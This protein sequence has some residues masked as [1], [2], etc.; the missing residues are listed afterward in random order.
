MRQVAIAF[1][2]TGPSPKAGHRICEIVLVGQENGNRD[3]SPVRFDFSAMNPTNEP[4]TF[5]VVLPALKAFV[6]DSTLIVHD[7][8]KWRRFLRAELRTIKRHGAGRLLN[9]VIDIGAW[10]HQRFPKQRRDVAAIARR[11]GIDVGK[12]LAGLEKEAEFLR[13]IAQKM[14]TSGETVSTTTIAAAHSIDPLGGQEV[15]AP[16]VQVAPV[17]PGS[18]RRKNWVERVGD[19]WRDLSGRR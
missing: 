12:E 1:A 6:R 11:L 17:M 13:L 14:D 7:S 4:I 3:G 8:G 16:V 19:F 9:N 10:A 2:T 18:Q 15:V 5:P